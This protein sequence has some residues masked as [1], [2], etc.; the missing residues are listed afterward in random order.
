MA[1]AICQS[2]HVLLVEAEQRRIHDLGTAVNAAVGAGATEISNSYGG[3]EESSDTR[4]STR[5]YYNHPGVVV[6]AS[7]G[8]CGYLNKAC[9][10]EPRGGELPGRLAGRRRGRRH[11][12]QRSRE[13]VWTSTVWSEGGSGCSEVFGAPLWQS[14]VANFSATGCGSGRSVADV[15]AIGD[16]NTGVDVYDSTPEGN[17]APT[18]WGVWGGTSVVLAD[19]RRRVRRSPAA[20]TASP[21]RPR[22]CTRTSAKKATL[23]DVVSGSNGTCAGRPSARP[24]SATTGRPASAARSASARSRSPGT[25]VEHNA[26]D[27]SRASPNRAR[28]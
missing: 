28:R 4:A 3:A 9:R 26:A 11:H 14:A 24:P 10:R 6:T 27:A 21:I 22:R 17:G 7:S 19:H 13:G 12:P 20:R 25:P 8:D 1:H 2:C 16:P 15:A 23:Y 5:R 18:G